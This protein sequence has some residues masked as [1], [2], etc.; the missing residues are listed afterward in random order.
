MSE[1]H[2]AA[3]RLGGQ[4]VVARYG[5]E[6]MRAIGKRGGRPRWEVAL[7]KAWE[8][9]AEARGR[10]RSRRKEV[11]AAHPAV[12]FPASSGKPRRLET[13]KKICVPEPIELGRERC[14]SLLEDVQN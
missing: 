13:I 9:H 4:A 12:P 14:C 1:R 8:H 7:A 2:R 10:A 5:R 11:L 6:W 3:G